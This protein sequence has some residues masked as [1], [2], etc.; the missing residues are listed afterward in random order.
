M[1]YS[2]IDFETGNPARHSACQVG[3]VTVSNGVIVDEFSSLIYPPFNSIIP[4]FSQIH[5][6]FAKDTVHS[7]IFPDVFEN[8]I[9]D[10]IAGNILVAHNETFDRSVFIR[11]L[12]FYELDYDKIMSDLK[13]PNAQQWECTL[14]IYRGYKFISGALK[15]LCDDLDIELQHHDALSDSRA[16]A[17]LYYKHLQKD[18]Q[19]KLSK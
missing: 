11:T 5:G 8:E 1:K 16:S 17:E 19:A 6:I 18:F 9:K 13:I 4:K 2:V 3:I 12:E 7:D 14:K 10:R 15:F